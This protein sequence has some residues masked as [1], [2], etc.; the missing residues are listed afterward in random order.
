MRRNRITEAAPRSETRESIVDLSRRS[1]SRLVAR[2]DGGFLG[3]LGAS[4]GA[5]QREDEE[6]F[7]LRPDGRRIAFSRTR[8]LYAT[9]MPT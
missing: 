9:K 7:T 1:P 3:E 2:I 4:N 5:S 8:N 6:V